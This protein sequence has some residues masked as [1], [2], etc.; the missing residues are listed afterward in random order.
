MVCGSVCGSLNSLGSSSDPAAVRQSSGTRSRPGPP[1]GPWAP[2]VDP[3]APLGSSGPLFSS[4]AG[5]AAR[6]PPPDFGRSAGTSGK[7]QPGPESPA[8]GPCEDQEDLQK[9]RVGSGHGD[10]FQLPS[11]FWDN[12]WKEEKK[13]RRRS[14]QILEFKETKSETFTSF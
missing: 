12:K 4:G 1:S 14:H 2:G 11:S 13:K 9:A 7:G 3:S 6:R 8:V 10:L 5:P